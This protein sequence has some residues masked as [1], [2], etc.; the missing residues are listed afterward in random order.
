MYGN[1]EGGY[2]SVSTGQGIP[3]GP[4]PVGP[5]YPTFDDLNKPP[6][7]PATYPQ[8]VNPA[9]PQAG[10]NMIPPGGPGMVPPVGQGMAPTAPGMAQ[11]MGTGMQPPI[12]GSPVPMVPQSQP[13]VVPVPV[14]E[15]VPV[16]VPAPIPNPMCIRCKGTGYILGGHA[17][18]C[19]GG[20][21]K[22]HTVEKVEVGL[23]IAGAVLGVLGAVAHAT[24]PHGPHW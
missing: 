4:A 16:P 22:M 7:Y 8:P 23:G 3:T 20:S 2:S 19:I 21:T 18:S 5:Q 9:I 6:S 15:V 1:N 24:S 13:V 10:P 11:P 14:P 12:M 17:C